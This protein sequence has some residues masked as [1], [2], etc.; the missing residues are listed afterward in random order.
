MEQGSPTPQVDESVRADAIQTTLIKV[1]ESVA[2]TLKSWLSGAIRDARSKRD[3]LLPRVRAWRKTLGGERPMPPV[4]TGAS[5][6]S[7]PLT[8]WA[9]TAVRSRLIEGVLETSPIVSAR[10][11]PGRRGD[12][13]NQTVANDLANFLGTEILNKRGLDGRTAIA[14][15]AAELTSLGTAAIKVYRTPDLVRNVSTPDGAFTQVRVPGRVKWEHVSF[16][17]LI[18]VDGYGTDT[19]AMP[20]IG[21]ECDRTWGEMRLWVELG[22]YDAAAID[23]IESFYRHEHNED[24]AALRSHTIVELYLDYDVNDD[25]IPEAVLIDWHLAAEEVLRI[26]PSPIP[27]GRRP[28]IMSR[29][30]FPP[31]ISDARGQGVSEKLEGSQEEADAV[32]NIAI[33]AGKRAINLVVLK[34]GRR[35]EE[36]LGPD[37]PALPSDIVTTEDPQEDIASVELGRPETAAGLI[38]LEEHTRMYVTRILGLDESRL[39]VVESGKRVPA[40]L[41]LSTMREGRVVVKAALSS[42]ADALT[43]ASYLTLDLWRVHVPL[44]ALEASLPPES[45]DALLSTVFAATDADTR[46]QF[47]LRVNAQDAAT[48]QDQ[49][50]AELLSINQF[51]FAFYDRLVNL[52]MALSNPAVPPTAKQPLLL[53]VERMERGVEALLGTLESIPNPDELLVQVGE[54]QRLLEESVAVTSSPQAIAMNA[55]AGGGGGQTAPTNGGMA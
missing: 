31:D 21:H 53:I 40:S 48:I 20:F 15:A 52:V 42:L 54:M 44:E 29:F 1:S 16:L 35:I 11:V 23:R 33:E 18:Y 38:A 37:A 51:L 47:V 32:H 25:G 46:R 41:G 43:D 7:V 50:R 5:N 9:V 6:L 22:Y 13:S 39:G 45:I 2:G 14:L 49:R 36:E 19:Q 34:A 55:M 8:M 27:D 17:D 30:D 4:R 26:V 3:E 28:I 10:P 12:V 24:P